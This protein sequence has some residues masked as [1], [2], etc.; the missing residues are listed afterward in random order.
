MTKF[1]ANKAAAEQKQTEALA[2]LEAGI[3]AL[4]T[5]GDWQEY[6]SFQSRFNQY[7]FRNI[8]M[9]REQ[10]PE[11]S[12]VAGYRVW[13]KMGR[14]VRKGEKGITIFAPVTRKIEDQESGDSKRIISGFKTATVF[15]I[16][17]TDGEELPDICNPI[18]GDDQGLFNALRDF[19]HS[20]VFK[21]QFNS[22]GPNGQC[23]FAPG[24]IE[25]TINPLLSPL[26]QAKTMAHELGHA[27]MHSAQDYRMHN[28]RSV[29]ELEAESVAFVV[30][31]ALDLDSGDY[32]FA[33]VSDWMSGTD[34]AIAQLK[35]SGSR[36]QKA[37]KE[38]IA[39]VEAAALQPVAVAA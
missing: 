39:A 25:I 11:A 8:V 9:I 22:T 23:Y 33:Y 18:Q 37:A 10:M 38:I 3:A 13:Q 21:T 12:R 36:I 7:S 16:S 26:H 4:A 20:K 27:L 32:S 2:K 35:E 15:D 1:K 34:D 17:Q 31:N 24:G 28:E 30:L 29:L 19:A 6:L 14:Q 5:S